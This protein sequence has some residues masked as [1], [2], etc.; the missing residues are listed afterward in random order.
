MNLSMGLIQVQPLLANKW[1]ATDEGDG[2]RVAELV[3]DDPEPVLD[4]TK[5]QGMGSQFCQAL[6]RRLAKDW[7]FEA[8]RKRLRCVELRGF[9]RYFWRALADTIDKDVH[10]HPGWQPRHC[11]ACCRELPKGGHKYCSDECKVDAWKKRGGVGSTKP[12]DSPPQAFERALA[13]RFPD[14][15]LPGSKFERDQVLHAIAELVVENQALK[16]ENEHLRQQL[17][18]PQGM[19]TDVGNA[20]GDL[21]GGILTTREAAAYLKISVSTLNGWR[22][23]GEQVIPFAKVGRSVRYRVEDLDAF[24]FTSQR[25]QTDRLRAPIREDRR[26]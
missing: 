9:H 1:G 21:P 18:L 19:R 25:M 23:T 2:A 11:W 26:R 17:E 24:L 15:R 7:G 10:R 14:A 16:K 6:F 22:C 3:L 4:F 8:I 5:V 12:H 20:K 13:K